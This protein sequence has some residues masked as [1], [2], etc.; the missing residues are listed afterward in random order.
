MN[1]YITNDW[2]HRSHEQYWCIDKYYYTSPQQIKDNII[3]W[4]INSCEKALRGYFNFD[5]RKTKIV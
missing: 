4:T 2:Q 1:K 3:K 5:I